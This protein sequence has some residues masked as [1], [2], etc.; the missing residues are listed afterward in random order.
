MSDRDATWLADI[1]IAARHVQRFISGVS[2]PD[3]L[4]AD[5]MRRSAVIHQMLILGEA[6]KRVSAEFR[7]QHPEIPWASMAGMRDVL[8]HQYRGIDIEQVWAAATEAVPDLT[9][10]LEPLIPPLDG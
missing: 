10:N 8:I 1:L 6:T 3:E 2:G 5:V 9:R 4:D 7:Q